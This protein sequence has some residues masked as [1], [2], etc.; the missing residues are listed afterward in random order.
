MKTKGKKI[1][2]KDFFLRKFD[3]PLTGISTKYSE[4]LK[5]S[6]LK[7]F[8]IVLLT[9]LTLY[10][11]LMVLSEESFL[12]FCL[13]FFSALP[14]KRQMHSFQL[15]KKQREKNSGEEKNAY[16]KYLAY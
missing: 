2:A 8:T 5:F 4:K 1:M 14:G 7:A 13:F 11:R 16:T 15:D 10:H 9:L 12:F 3:I 6:R